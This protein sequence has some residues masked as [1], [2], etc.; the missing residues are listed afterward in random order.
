MLTLASQNVCHGIGRRQKLRVLWNKFSHYDCTLLQETWTKNAE[1]AK[2]LLRCSKGK[3]VVDCYQRR[4]RVSRGCA[5]VANGRHKFSHEGREQNGRLTFFIL[6]T[7]VPHLKKIGII[8]FY[9]PTLG[10]KEDAEEYT[11]N[12]NKIK[13]IESHLRQG[14][15]GVII[16][17]GDFNF[18]LDGKLDCPGNPPKYPYGGLVKKDL[19]EMLSELDLVDCYRV[20]QPE[21]QATSYLSKCQKNVRRRLD[22]FYISR[23]ASHL[24]D[25]VSHEWSGIDTDHKVVI[26][27]LINLDVNKLWKRSWKHNDDLLRDY[28]ITYKHE[29]GH[30][31]M[32]ICE[33]EDTR[34][35][36]SARTRWDFIKMEIAEKARALEK[37]IREKDREEAIRLEKEIKEGTKNEAENIS[38]IHRLKTL[39]FNEEE[40]IQDRYARN[41]GMKRQEEGEKCSKYFFNAAK[42][43]ISTANIMSLSMDGIQLQHRDV[44]KEVFNFYKKLYS[45]DEKLF[46]EEGWEDFIGTERHIEP[47]D[48]GALDAPISESEMKSALE[49]MASGKCP[50]TDG[51]STGFYKAFWREIAPALMEA[52]KEG[53]EEG[54]FSETQKRSVVRLILKKDKDAGEL[55]NWRPISLINVDI[56]IFS[57]A[58]AIRLEKVAGKIIGEEQLGFVPGRLI[59]EGV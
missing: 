34:S 41:A 24:I 8:N 46:R 52:L 59:F 9:A 25:S 4:G 38:E 42:K 33:R 1:E 11:L 51:L 47:Q 54:E 13:R 14:G 39:W 56:K 16:V 29:L 2:E 53:V 48:R 23:S 19:E 20:K 26:L 3:G 45:R 27:R 17:A 50:G 40:R 10:S 57:R 6:H 28:P 18:V 21:G 44:N 15:A 30:S 36:S 49:R 43:R 7:E 58:L 12:I 55:K 5:L 32:T 37:K 31:I 35:I 22:K